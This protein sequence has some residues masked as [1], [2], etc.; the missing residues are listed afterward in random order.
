M[1]KLYITRVSLPSF[2][3]CKEVL[4]NSHSFFLVGDGGS[5]P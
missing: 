3:C 5:P 1:G 4:P 2:K